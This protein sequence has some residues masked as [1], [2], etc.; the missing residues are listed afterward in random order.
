MTPHRIKFF[1]SIRFRLSAIIAGVIV[2]AI[3]ALSAYNAAQSLDRETDNFRTLTAGAA[4]AYAAA[5]SDD[6]AEQNKMQALSALRGIRDLQ[7][8]VQTDV[9]L[10]NGDVF[11]ELGTGAWL[12]NQDKVED[13]LWRVDQIRIEIP[14]VKS[15]E[16]IGTLGMLADIKPLRAQIFQSLMLTIASSIMIALIGILLAQ[17]FVSRLTAPLQALTKEMANIRDGR[18]LNVAD[19]KERSDET[20]L[21]TKTF[22]DMI[23]T[24]RERDREIAKHMDTLEDTVD[25]RTRDLR[26]ARDDAEAA[27]AAKSDF[28][29]TMSHEIRTPMNGMMVMAEMLGAADL[30]PRHKRYADII[31]RSGNSL[32]TIINDILD[33]SK[34][35]AGQLDLEIIPVS[36]ERLATDVSSLFWEK[37]R[38]SKLE[39]ATYVSPRV[40]QEILA[41]PTRLNQVISNLVNNA[42]KFTE[43]GGVLIHIDAEQREDKLITLKFE[44]IDTGIG[45]PEDKVDQ[46]FESFSQADQ[47]T[48]RQFGGTG[49][50][51]T[52]CRRLVTAMNGKIWVTSEVGQGSVF[53]VEIPVEIQVPA[54]DFA[55]AD[56]SVG[57]KLPKGVLKRSVAQSLKDQGCKIKDTQPD[58]WISNSVEIG[59]ETEPVILLSDLGDTKADRL[60][61]T[62]QAVDLIANPFDRAD[63]AELLQRARTRNYRG[64]TA[65]EEQVSDKGTLKQFEGLRVLAVDDNAVNREVLREALSTLHAEAVFAEDGQ[66]ALEAFQSEHFDIVLM[67]GSMPVMDGF[68]STRRM[69]AFEASGSIQPT[70]IFALTAQVVGETESAWSDAGADGHILKPFTLEK[71]SSVFTEIDT[72]SENAE[73][74]EVSPPNPGSIHKLFDPETLAQLDSLGSDPGGIRGKVWSMFEDKAP[75]MLKDLH[76]ALQSDDNGE[77][78]RKAHALKSM[79]LSSGLSGLA[80]ALQTLEEHAK[81]HTDRTSYSEALAPI[82]SVY[83]ATLIEMKA[84][85]SV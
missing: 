11:V 5:I 26:I 57:I 42:L 19:L 34:I 48:T 38:S 60:L 69:R 18:A 46:I 37:A 84:H 80:S 39:L 7:S 36:P 43:T 27:N 55:S 66:Q 2:F 29:A 12:L 15:G 44:V 16:Q 25:E 45:I 24:I 73:E 31:H 8:I 47:S 54:P 52:V 85:A 30:T 72:T 83:D 74:V 4:T 63:V 21:L 40:P 65:L 59:D 53:H 56:L 35:E 23:G 62:G 64:I 75:A 33:L 61:S 76:A 81:V 41:D 6:V 32:L 49:L 22:T 78:A 14:I 51:L 58:F 79:A 67:D 71:L 20:G 68:E 1:N 50:G 28:L 13:S 70:P 3:S 17:V 82:Q 9:T 10:P 77:L